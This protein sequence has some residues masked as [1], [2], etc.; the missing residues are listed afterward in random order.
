M[1]YAEETAQDRQ[2]IGAEGAAQDRQAI[3]VF[4]IVVAIMIATLI[5][6]AT[7][8]LQSQLVEADTAA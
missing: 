6:V 2:A 8:M 7:V 5:A 1:I 3:G 4:V